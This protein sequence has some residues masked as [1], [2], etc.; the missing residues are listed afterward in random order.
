[1]KGF[2]L[3]YEMEGGVLTMLNECIREENLRG[4]EVKDLPSLKSL[5]TSGATREG[6]VRSGCMWYWD[7]YL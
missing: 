7:I 3:R 4:S 1:M 2:G 5:T 6:G